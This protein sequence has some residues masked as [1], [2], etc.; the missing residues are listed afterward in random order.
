[1]AGVARVRIMVAESL[2]NCILVGVL[3][4]KDEL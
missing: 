4:V 2:E 1:M 3:R